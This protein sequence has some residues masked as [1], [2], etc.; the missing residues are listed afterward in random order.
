LERMEQQLE[1]TST[2][3]ETLATVVGVVASNRSDGASD[4]VASA[5]GSG[6]GS[7]GDRDSVEVFVG[8]RPRQGRRHMFGG[9][10][11]G[12]ALAAA[13]RTVELPFHSLHSYFLH[14]GDA[15]SSVEFHVHRSRDSRSFATRRV[16]GYQNGRSIFELTASF[17]ASRDGFDHA[18]PAPLDVPAPETLLPLMRRKALRHLTNLTSTPFD[19]LDF[20]P[21]SVVDPASPQSHPPT[22]CVWFRSVAPLPDDPAV[23]A[24]ALAYASDL[25]MLATTLRPHRVASADPKVFFASLDHSLWVHR[26]FRA[27]EW[28]LHEEHSPSAAGGRAVTFGKI[29]TRD[30]TLVATTAQEG[31]VRLATTA[32]APPSA[33]PSSAASASTAASAASAASAATAA[34]ASTAA[35][36]ARPGPA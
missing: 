23:H 21:V 22:Q 35:T 2:A 9:Q 33:E 25:Y 29:F 32:A 14:G 12:Q 19:V 3:D 13:S 28:L 18:D 26:A 16:V 4:R 5:S 34:S 10:L 15:G 24:S 8:H 36:A 31:V 27:D 30:G 20:R 11:V 6:S 1:Q 7:D 17:T